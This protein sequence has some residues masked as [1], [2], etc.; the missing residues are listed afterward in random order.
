MNIFIFVFI[1][2]VLIIGIPTYFITNFIIK[3]CV[4]LK[5]WHRH[6][7]RSFTITISLFILFYFVIFGMAMGLSDA[8]QLKGPIYLLGVFLITAMIY[9]MVVC[10]PVGVL[11]ILIS[12]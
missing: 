8:G 11:T 5:V 12:L 3:R 1:A 2:S 4:N 10:V 9:F 6:G 7:I